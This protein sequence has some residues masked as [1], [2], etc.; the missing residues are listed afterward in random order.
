MLNEI[1]GKIEIGCNLFKPFP[2]D[3]EVSSY[4]Y[5]KVKNLVLNQVNSLNLFCQ[6]HVVK[7]RML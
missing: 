5:M 4:N 1:L 3:V 6:Y 7:L 2:Y